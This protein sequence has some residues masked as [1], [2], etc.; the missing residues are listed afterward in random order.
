M[1]GFFMLSILTTNF[2][3]TVRAGG[4]AEMFFSVDIG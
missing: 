2:R 3:A 4:I 1:E